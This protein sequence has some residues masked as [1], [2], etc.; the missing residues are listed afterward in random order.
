MEFGDIL[1]KFALGLAPPQTP[2]KAVNKWMRSVSLLTALN[3]SIIGLTALSII[4]W[5]PLNF[6]IAK[7]RDVEAQGKLISGQA[8]T[9]KGLNDGLREMRKAQIAGQIDRALTK[10]CR[11][12]QA[13]KQPGANAIMMQQAYND[14]NKDVRDLNDKYTNLGGI[15]DIN[16]PCDEIL[17]GGN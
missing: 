5:V 17:I 8:D 2:D 7:A 15:Y 6:G 4:G 1:F 11:Y 10:S 12:A 3:G 14:A 16:R 13:G 9:L